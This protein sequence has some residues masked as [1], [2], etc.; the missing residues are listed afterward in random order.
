MP[1]I[2][3]KARLSIN[4]EKIVLKCAVLSIALA[5]LPVVREITRL[6]SIIKL[7]IFLIK[8]GMCKGSIN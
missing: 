7:I 8:S 5:I 1:L 6:K 4:Y 2:F 3:Y